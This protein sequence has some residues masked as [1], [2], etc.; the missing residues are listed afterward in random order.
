VEVIGYDLKSHD[1]NQKMTD[2]ETNAVCMLL[3]YFTGFAEASALATHYDAT[4][5]PYYLPDSIT[6]DEIERVVYHYLGQNQ[7][8]LEMKGGALVV[9]ALSLAFP[10]PAFKAPAAVEKK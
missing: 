6:N 1:K 7:D 3:G 8:K 5:L 4:A 2:Y 10:N 9:A